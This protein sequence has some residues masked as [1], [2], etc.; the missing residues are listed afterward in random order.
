MNQKDGNNRDS[1]RPVQAME[2][3]PKNNYGGGDRNNRPQRDY[4]NNKPRD[5][6]NNNRG[7]G[8]RGGRDNRDGRDG[9]GYLGKRRFEEGNDDFNGGDDDNQSDHGYGGKS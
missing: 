4:H 3:V 6:Y 9:G 5:H 8:Y 2:F 7:G 1:D